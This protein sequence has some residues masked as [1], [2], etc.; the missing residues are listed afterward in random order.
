MAKYN[1]TLI[2]ERIYASGGVLKYVDLNGTSPYATRATDVRFLKLDKSKIKLKFVW[3]NGAKVS[4]LVKK[5]SA[6]YGF[7]ASFFTADNKGGYLPIADT[8]IGNMIL[9]TSYDT[10]NGAQQTKWHG[11]GVKNG[12]PVIGE[13][14]INDDYTDGFLVKTT[15]FLVSNGN[16][17]YDWFRLPS[18]EGTAADIGVGAN[19]IPVRRQRTFVGIDSNGD[20]LLAVSDGNGTTSDQGLNLEEMSLYLKAKGSEYAINLDG[21]TSSVIANQFGSLGQNQGVNE[22]VVHHAVLVYLLDDTL[23]L[24][25]EKARQVD[26]EIEYMMSFVDGSGSG[27][28][29]WAIDY[30]SQVYD[31]MVSKGLL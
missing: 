28:E 13:L 10:L 31:I 8:K 27:V 16:L 9:N 5:Y 30:L 2:K 4:D 19:G 21:G 18:V 7:N 25:R 11:F 26:N 14:N 17:A 20:L 22:R 12:V 15:P 3:E 24:Q 6:D 23:E 29:Q 1:P